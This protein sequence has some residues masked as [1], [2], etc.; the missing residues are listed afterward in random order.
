M[1]LMKT[2]HVFTNGSGK[3]GNPV[4]IIVDES[5]VFNKDKRQQMALNSGFSEIVFINDIKKRNISIFSPQR[6]I[7]FA[8]H[9]VIGTAYFLNHEYKSLATQ[10][11]S[12]NTLIDTWSENSLTWVKGELSI[13]PPWNY[14]QLFNV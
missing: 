10:L 13:L 9:A 12:M 4:G 3:F 6:E 14:E 5:Q 8:G 2:L 1:G 7:P 11:F